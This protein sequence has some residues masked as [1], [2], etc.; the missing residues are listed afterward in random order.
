MA[1]DSMSRLSAEE[2]SAVTGEP[3]ERL[4]RLRSLQLIGS[5]G[6][7]GFAPEDAERIRLIQFLE[8]REIGLETIARG[9]RD[10][11]TLS[12]V[13]QFLFPH[14]LGP[15]YSLDQAVD[16]VGLDAEV[17]RRL[18]DAAGVSD[19][20]IDKYDLE[21]LRN[22][23][24]ALDAGF[25]E[26]A[27][28]Q[29]ARVYADALERVAEGEVHLFHFYV[30]E[31]LKST[32][33][34]GRELVDNRK[35]VQAHLLPVVEPMIRYFHRL[36]LA[37]AVRA[38]MVL[39]LA[40]NLARPV[41]TDSGGQLRLAILFVDM[42]S[43]TPLTEVMGDATAARIVERFSELVHAAAAQFDG[44]IV[45]SR[46]RCI[47]AHLSRATRGGQLRSRHRDRE[48]RGHRRRGARRWRRDHRPR[49]AG[50]AR[51]GR[52]PFTGGAP[53]VRHRDRSGD[54]RQRSAANELP[55]HLRSGR[56]GGRP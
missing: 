40:P 51:G 14:G 10:E 2:L 3:V 11:A 23:K 32:G 43:Y 26:A 9:E 53:A 38:D 52:D 49:A 24:V 44:R 17:A 54:P 16:I 55:L 27:L 37:K 42:S 56:R 7:E 21:M 31:G 4:Q 18:R 33:L 5:E 15:T 12:S 30:H 46:R 28:L 8:R 19:D 34:S 25:P 36:G 1:E 41:Q 29:L 22:A 48:R 47:P 35:S 6:D 45:V 20:R 50:R 13:V 39:H